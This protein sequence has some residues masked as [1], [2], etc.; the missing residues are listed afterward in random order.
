MKK[1]D[2][3]LNLSNLKGFAGDKEKQQRKLLK[4]QTINNSKI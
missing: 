2:F 1:L 3:N 4:P